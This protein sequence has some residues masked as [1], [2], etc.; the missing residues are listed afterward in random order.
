MKH[1]FTNKIEDI[2][3]KYYPKNSEHIFK[4]SELI[5]YLNQKTRSAN[6]GSKSR[7][8]FASIYAVYVLVEDYIKNGFIKSGKY[9]DYDGAKYT[10]IHNRQC[11][12]PFGAK[13]QNHA[14]NHRMNKEFEKFFPTCDYIPIMRDAETNRYWINENLLKFKINRKKINIAKIIIEIIDDYVDIKKNAFDNFIETCNQLK[15]ISNKNPEKIIEF[16]SGLLAPN[17][18]ARIFEIVSFAI[19]KYFYYDQTVYFGFDLGFCNETSWPFFSSNR[20]NRRKKI[21]S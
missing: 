5:Q 21:F 6:K 18:D 15:T 17:V 2:L 16:V 9:S 19:L 7:G 3:K 14:L 12:L 1:S 13:L 8:S 10:N 20:N 4:N 11:E